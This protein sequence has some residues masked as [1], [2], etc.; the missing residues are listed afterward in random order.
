LSQASKKKKKCPGRERWIVKKQKHF[1]VQGHRK[2]QVE[3]GMRGKEKGGARGGKQGGPAKNHPKVLRAK[4]GT[5]DI[6][7]SKAVPYFSQP[8]KLKKN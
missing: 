1:W 3:K 2:S 7:K 5:L 4:G 8:K 6:G